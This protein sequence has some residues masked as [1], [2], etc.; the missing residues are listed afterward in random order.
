MKGYDDNVSSDLASL[1]SVQ[2]EALDRNAASGKAKEYY[3][4]VQVTRATVYRNKLY[5]RVGNFLEEHQVEIT[6]HENEISSSCTCGEARNICKHAIALLYSWV[7]DGR[8][9]RNIGKT[10]IEIKKMDKERLLE[11][12]SNIIRL[13]PDFIDLFLARQRP[14]WDEIDPDPAL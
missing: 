14:D 11:I 7:N 10:L 12:V 1:D 4:N 9:F 13:H 2:I 5:G 3:E 6:V 8:D